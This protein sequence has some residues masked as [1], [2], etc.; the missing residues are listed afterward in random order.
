MTNFD[1]ETTTGA[2]TVTAFFDTGE[3]AQI[4]KND[5]VAV[6]LSADAITIVGSN[7]DSFNV[8]EDHQRGFWDSLTNFFMPDD[9]RRTYSEGL[10]RGGFALSVRTSDA[11]YKQAIDVL[12]RDGAVDLDERS[13]A[14]ESEGWTRS[15]G[16]VDNVDAAYKPA[17]ASTAGFGGSY[18]G[19][20]G[21][22]D[23]DEATNPDVRERIG[24]GTASQTAPAAHGGPHTYVDPASPASDAAADAAESRSGGTPSVRRDLENGRTRVRSYIVE[25]DVNR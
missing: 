16:G 12:D 1:S 25:G 9:E 3:H 7:A 13:M 14:W 19:E 6:G 11:L 24:A 15:E 20:D 2:R 22:A 10:R 17:D 5:L 23:I 4:A 18:A 21:L 8:A